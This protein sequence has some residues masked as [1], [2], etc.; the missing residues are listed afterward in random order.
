MFS[1]NIISFVILNVYMLIAINTVVIVAIVTSI[2]IDKIKLWRYNKVYNNIKTDVY[3][4]IN[5]AEYI[6]EL[7]IKIKNNYIY[8]VVLDIMIEYVTE[9]GLNISDNFEKLGYID[10]LIKKGEKELNFDI[11]KK[12]GLIKSPKAYDIL[13]IGTESEDFELKYMSYYALSLIKVEYEKVEKVINNLIESRI[14]R[15]RQIEIV[16][17][18]NLPAEQY[19]KLLDTQENELGKIILLRAL[20]D[21]E[22]MKNKIYSDRIVQYLNEGKEIRLS[23]VLTLGKSANEEYLPLLMNLYDK[24][25]AWEVRAAIAKSLINFSPESIIEYLKKIIYDDEWWVRFNAVEV[26]A[27]LGT[28]GIDTLIDLSLDISNEKVSNLAYYILNSNKDV[29]NVVR[30]Y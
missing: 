10:Y 21:K 24:E 3:R 20:Q 7:K 4:Y 29:N 26:I 6:D 27:R 9:T 19:L 17:N 18:Y 30:N 14:I 16:D 11:V 23:T 5:N 28:S 15:D 25:S 13:M 2:I 1:N 8:R 12:L 22:D